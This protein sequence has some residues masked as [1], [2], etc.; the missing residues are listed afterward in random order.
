MHC[1]WKWLWSQS[2]LN[3]LTHSILLSLCVCRKCIGFRFKVLQTSTVFVCSNSGVCSFFFNRS[4]HRCIHVW[5]RERESERELHLYDIEIQLTKKEEQNV[6]DISTSTRF[7]LC[8]CTTK[9]GANHSIYSSIQFI[10]II[11]CSWILNCVH[12]YPYQFQF[13]ICKW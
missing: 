13:Q 11:L 6:I 4:C 10:Y 5:K 9:P 2:D 3:G 1:V 7:A 8:V 12:P